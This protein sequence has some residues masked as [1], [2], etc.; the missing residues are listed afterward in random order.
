MKK[1][2]EA[3]IEIIK[4]SLSDVITTSCTIG[5][6]DCPGDGCDCYGGDD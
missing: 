4:F 1:Y 2:E 5:D 3:S 6:E